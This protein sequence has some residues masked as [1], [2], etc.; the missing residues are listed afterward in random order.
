MNNSTPEHKK[1][2]YFEDLVVYQKARPRVR[3]LDWSAI[4]ARLALLV[5]CLATVSSAFA[6]DLEPDWTIYLPDS[7]SG[8]RYSQCAAYNPVTDKIYVGGSGNCVIVID[9]A[10]GSKIARIPTKS[11]SSAMF[12]SPVNGRV[13]CVGNLLTVIDGASDTV[14]K[15]LRVSRDAFCYNSRSEKLYAYAGFR[16][17]NLIV[18]DTK[19]DSVLDTLDVGQTSVCYN[20]HNDR[21]YCW[22]GNRVVVLKG[23]DLSFVVNIPVGG[24]SGV[25]CYNSA[26]NKVY[27]ANYSTRNVTLIDGTTNTVLATIVADSGLVDMCCNPRD[28]KIY[29]ANGAHAPHPEESDCIGPGWHAH[30]YHDYGHSS[31]TVIDGASDRVLTT[32]HTH[33][34]PYVLS[35][36]SA[37]NK[38]L[39]V[40][41]GGSLSSSLDSLLTL[42]KTGLALWSRAPSGS[43][44]KRADSTSGPTVDIIDG[45]SNKLTASAVLTQAPKAFCFDPRRGRAYCVTGDRDRSGVVLLNEATGVVIDELATGRSPGRVCYNSRDNKLY[46]SVPMDNGL[47]VL[48]GATNHVLNRVTLGRTPGLLCYNSRNDKLYCQISEAN[49]VLV[50]DG[51]T[52]EVKSKVDMGAPIWYD[53]HN[54]RVYAFWDFREVVVTDGVTDTMVVVIPFYEANAICYNPGNDMV[55]CSGRAGVAV[56]DA[57]QSK[58]VTVLKVD[59]GA[60]VLCC[61]YRNNKVYCANPWSPVLYVIDGASD[62]LDTALALHGSTRALCYNPRNNRMYSAGNQGIRVFDAATGRA[63]ARFSAYSAVESMLYDPE[64]NCVYC[65][66]GNRVVVIDGATNKILRTYSLGRGSYKTA[67][68]TAQNRVYLADQQGTSISVPNGNA[69]HSGALGLLQVS[70]TPPGA[71]ISLDSLKTRTVTPR[72]FA[73]VAAGQYNL[74]LDKRGYRGWD[75]TVTVTDGQTTAVHATLKPPPDSLRIAHAWGDSVVR[76]G[77][78]RGFKFSARSQFGY[79]FHIYKVSTSA[80]IYHE[81]PWP[82]WGFRLKIYRGDAKTLLYQSPVLEAARTELGSDIVDQLSEPVLIDSGEFYVFLAPADSSGQAANDSLWGSAWRGMLPI[83]VLVRR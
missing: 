3:G 68:N 56:I 27:C 17:N 7:L 39:A 23:G 52:D 81:K 13:Y 44:A 16:D 26:N 50:L 83:S 21:V 75:S 45:V 47:M 61:D 79:P 48:D 58:L 46:C 70:S 22:T 18:I 43:G 72:L 66:D 36:D 30:P 8:L 4:K 31:V 42:P 1:V 69:I 20:P 40:C 6:Q 51:K 2:R 54:N 62:R 5:V 63:L 28:N 33:G 78:E 34:R 55:Y 19:T 57:S 38:V 35:Y 59:G 37:S 82:D 14:V 29:L 60:N 65:E 77:S 24:G 11:G 41:E 53:P 12:C 64:N 67:L 73:R 49:Q 71:T 74:G 76:K 80:L 32:V 10:T 15:T 25:L 9:C